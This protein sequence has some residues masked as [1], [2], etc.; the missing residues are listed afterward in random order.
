MISGPRTF[1]REIKKTTQ[2]QER[3]FKSDHEV[4]TFAKCELDTRADTICAGINFRALAYTGQSCDVKGFHD[5]FDSLKNIPVA[6]VATAIQ[7]D[8]LTFILIINEA[9]YFGSSMDHSLINPNQIWSYGIP[10][11]DD[12]YDKTRDFG[13]SHEDLY[14]L[15]DTIG[16]AVFFETFVPSYNDLN[17]SPHN[18]LT[19]GDHE[20]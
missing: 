18:I 7:R 19:D 17:N 20:H 12:P 8:G 13:I 11:S 5:S 2:S 1:A 10:V 9:L 6:Q 14:V 3:F 16:S 15:F 4:N